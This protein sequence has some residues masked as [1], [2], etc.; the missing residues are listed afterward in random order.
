[1][2]NDEKFQMYANELIRNVPE[3]YIKHLV[4]LF[5]Q[6]ASINMGSDINEQTL[7]RVIYHVKKDYSYI[8]VNYVASAF[9]RGSLGKIGDGRG[10]LVPKTILTWLG[11][12]SLDYNRMIANKRQKDKLDD[13]SV[14]MDL[15]KYP[16][17]SAI[18]K[19]I[20]WYRKGILSI[21][22]WDK[23]PLKKV[24]E[25]IA[26]GHTPTVEHFGIKN[27]LLR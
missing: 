6:E 27:N 10:R 1:M 14:A 4:T 12:A 2:E 26:D 15:H 22:D 24:S 5:I 8:P 17:G 13:V 3:E 16:V 11:D 23:V 19:K 25:M 18:E 20:E 21:D 7:E 9:I